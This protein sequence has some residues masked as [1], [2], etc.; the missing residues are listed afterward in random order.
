MKNYCK[1]VFMCMQVGVLLGAHFSPKSEKDARRKSPVRSPQV[2]YT[3][4]GRSLAIPLTK[5]QEMV[6]NSQAKSPSQAI[7]PG[8]YIGWFDDQ[9][10]SPD[11]RD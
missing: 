10:R 9:G 5:S 11:W 4:S 6:I 2:S 3:S 8:D 7:S 1:I